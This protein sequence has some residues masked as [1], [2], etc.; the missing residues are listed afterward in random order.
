MRKS[1]LI[2]LL[3]LALGHVPLPAAGAGAGGDGYRAWANELVADWDGQGSHERGTD[4]TGFGLAGLSLFMTHDEVI[5]RLE[6]G[7]T[8]FD[9]SETQR[10]TCVD[11]RIEDIRSDAGKG[12][13]C[14]DYVIFT[15][16]Y[17]DGDAAHVKAE[18][19]EDVYYEPGS[20]IVIKIEYTR[21]HAQRSVDL[22]AAYDAVTSEYGYQSKYAHLKYYIGHFK[23]LKSYPYVDSE[24]QLPYLQMYLG[25][26]SPIDRYSLVLSAGE[27]LRK[28]LEA[29]A[30]QMV[31]DATEIREFRLPWG[32]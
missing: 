25:S 28:D 7:G 11:D 5:E 3:V 16:Q 2:C 10:V 21:D 4:V 30:D 20:S 22:D 6:A 18:F 32:M 29:R 17:G 23:T 13:N 9:I 19:K 24:W 8:A 1:L 14:V 31:R 26:V 27:A 15:L 12:A